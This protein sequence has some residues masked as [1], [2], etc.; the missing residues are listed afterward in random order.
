M[1]IRSIPPASA[2]LALRP[3]PAPPPTIGSPAATLARN[4]SS[5]ALRESWNMVASITGVPTHQAE[6]GPRG[7]GRERRVV[8]VLVPRL[9]PDPGMTGQPARHGLE[10]GPVGDGVFERAAR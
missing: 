1:M 2:H 5:N 3:V 4:R 6:E 8:D 9:D 10:Q 7:G